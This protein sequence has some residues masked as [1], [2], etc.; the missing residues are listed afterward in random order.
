MTCPLSPCKAEAEVGTQGLQLIEHV[1]N[2]RGLRLDADV[3]CG[4][5]QWACLR[6]QRSDVRLH[7]RA[8][9]VAPI[10]YRYGHGACVHVDEARVAEIAGQVVVHM[11]CGVQASLVHPPAEY[12]PYS[13]GGLAL[14]SQEREA[15]HQLYPTSGLCDPDQ[16]GNDP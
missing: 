15:L 1:L 8:D 2:E 7:D 11:T 12:A 5:Q 4:G 10:A 6:C 13:S 16:L 14:G 3:I 9:L